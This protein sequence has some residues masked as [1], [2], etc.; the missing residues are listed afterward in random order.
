MVV[1]YF[2]EF[3]NIF[4]FLRCSLKISRVIDFTE[5]C[6]TY[7]NMNIISLNWSQLIKPSRN[8][9]FVDIVEW[10]WFEITKFYR[11][12]FSD[13]K[14]CQFRWLDS[15][16]RRKNINTSK[17]HSSGAEILDDL[18][19]SGFQNAGSVSQI[20]LRPKPNRKVFWYEISDGKFH[21]KI[22]ALFDL[23]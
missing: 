8:N 1:L 7:F 2:T 11:I 23:G 14:F 12:C 22:L 3:R 10:S 20:Y 15:C 18:N 13:T 9:S 6:Y 5:P 4:L 19:V 21:F 17:L 16:W